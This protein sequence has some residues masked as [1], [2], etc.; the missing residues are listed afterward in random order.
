MAGTG[1]CVHE[2]ITRNKS[3]LPPGTPWTL[4]K[5]KARCSLGFPHTHREQTEMYVSDTVADFRPGIQAWG[6]YKFNALQRQILTGW[7]LG[8]LGISDLRV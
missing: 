6:E 5:G 8:R 3:G 1:S 7:G 4:R 2:P